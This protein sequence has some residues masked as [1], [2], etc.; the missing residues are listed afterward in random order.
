MSTLTARQVRKS[1]EPLPPMPLAAESIREGKPEA[2]GA[3]L[4]QSDDKR[5]SSGLWECSPGRFTWDFVWDEFVHV[6]SGHV[7]VTTQDGQRIELRA[8][9]FATFPRGLKTEWQVL[10]KVRKTFTVR[11]PDPLELSGS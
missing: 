8:G 3:V 11:T 2:F 4:L 5:V 9:D 10:E 6:H 1:S 7:I